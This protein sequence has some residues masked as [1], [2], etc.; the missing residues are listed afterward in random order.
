MNQEKEDFVIDTLIHKDLV[1]ASCRKMAEFF[2][3]EGK[4]EY[5][6][7][8]V[9]RGWLHDNS[10]FTEEEMEAFSK[11]NDSEAS[12]REAEKQLSPE[13]KEFLKIHYKHNTH[14]P[15]HWDDITQMPEMDIVEMC[16]D[17]HARSV[18]YETDLIDFVSKRQE[19]RFHFPQDMFERIIL[20]CLILVT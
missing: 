1:L 11:V 4:L 17:W 5:S 16:C 20:Y 10:K 18:Q 15:E 12:L 8:I 9:T 7:E 19:S 6:I 13:M 14:H 3:S 2:I